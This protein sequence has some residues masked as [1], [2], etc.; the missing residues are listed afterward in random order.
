MFTSGT[1]SGPGFGK[2]FHATAALVLALCAFQVSAQV[3]PPYGLPNKGILRLQLGTS[4]ADGGLHSPK[5]FV[6][7]PSGLSQSIAVSGKCGLFLGGPSS[8]GVL[9]ALGGNGVPGLGDT[10]IGV[11]DGPKG[12]ACYRMTASIGESIKLG[13][14]ADVAASPLIDANAFYRLE[15]DVEVKANAEF[16]LQILAAGAVTEEFR[17]RSGSTIV[18]GEGS[19]AP[20]SPDRILNCQ[21]QSDSGPDSGARDNC[22]WIVDALGQQFR[23]IPL[24]GE[25]S[26][27]GGGDFGTTGYANNSLLYLTKAAIGALGCNSSQV[28]QGTNTTTVGD[29]TTTAQC[30]VTRVDPTGLGGSCT[31]AVGYILRD[32]A[33]GIGQGCELNKVPGEQ[34]AA[35]TDILFPPEPSTALGAEPPTT[36]QFS[37]NVPGVLVPFTPQRCVGTVVADRNGKPTIAEVLSV[38][39]FVPDLVPATPQKDWACILNSSQEYVGGGQMRVRQTILFWGDIIFRR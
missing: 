6:H 29:G 22:R 39:G 17:L 11:S 31:T 25:G 12:V 36:I 35:S 13:L 24:S 32:S 30:G 37:T 18:A 8:L 28:P 10:S 9:T 19:T 33:G 21:A 4:A 38:P 34:L 2:Y 15:L 5:R 27:E 23:L 1:R 26:L 7:E 3:A 14:G 20:G 16:L